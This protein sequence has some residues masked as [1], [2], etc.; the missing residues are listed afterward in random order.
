MGRGLEID[1]ETADR[2]TVLV[3]KDQRRYLLD[4]VI[5]HEKNGKYMHPEDYHES[6]TKLI[7]ALDTLIKY[8][9]G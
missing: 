3:L 2:I 4:E 7:P 6:K 9:G 8:W 1:F 5:Q